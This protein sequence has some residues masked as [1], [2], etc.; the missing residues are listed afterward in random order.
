MYYNN[1]MFLGNKKLYMIRYLIS[2]LNKK[3][4]K[5]RVRSPPT[6]I[7]EH[8][9]CNGSHYFYVSLDV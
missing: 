2:M 3:S 9:N 5:Q 8:C 6:T 7:K 1:Y 4:H